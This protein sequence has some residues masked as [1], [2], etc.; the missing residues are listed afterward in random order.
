MGLRKFRFKRVPKFK[1]GGGGELKIIFKDG[2]LK[3]N[4]GSG[5]PKDTMHMFGCNILR[6]YS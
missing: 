6:L 2:D 5:I 3:L 1:G 4:R